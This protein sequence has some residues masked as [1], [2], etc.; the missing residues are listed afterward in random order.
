MIRRPPRSTLFPYTTLFRS[1]LIAIDRLESRLEMA[2]R[3]GA[4]LTINASK[5]TEKERLD[6]TREHTNTGPDIVIDCTGV[7]QS[8]PECL[9]MVRYGGTRVGA[10]SVLGMG[11]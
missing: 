6:L 4:T 2:R 8:F 5:T 9:H 3:F 11:A 1:K 10:G 7:A